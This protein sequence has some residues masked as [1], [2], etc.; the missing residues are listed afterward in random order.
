MTSAAEAKCTSS[1]LRMGAERLVEETQTDSDVEVLAGLA[2]IRKRLLPSLAER[3]FGDGLA[4]RGLLYPKELSDLQRWLT[5]VASCDTTDDAPD[6][7]MLATA[8]A[9][10]AGRAKEDSATLELVR[11]IA[12]YLLREYADSAAKVLR[13]ESGVFDAEGRLIEPELQ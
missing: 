12:S 11:V 6:E 7:I 8:A 4:P 3:A 2:T 9:W 10:I 1:E 13:P 5:T